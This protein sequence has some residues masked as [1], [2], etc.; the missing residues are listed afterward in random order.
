MDVLTQLIH[1]EIK[2]QYKSVRQFSIE[3]GIPQTTL[4]SALKKGVDGTSYAT[5]VR[6][7][8]AL[9]IK[10]PTQSV[11]VHMDDEVITLLQKL[12]TLDEKGVHT[13]K[14]VLEM[15]YNRCSKQSL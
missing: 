8:D 1:T 13:V 5:I 11:P 9:D 4:A 10:V 12:S 6:I 3:M 2:R 14:T 15:E 7:C